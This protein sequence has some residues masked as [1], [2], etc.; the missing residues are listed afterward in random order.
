[1]TI[2]LGLVLVLAGVLVAVLQVRW[3]ARSTPEPVRRWHVS[4][5]LPR[6]QR[7]ASDLAIGGLI[8]AGA[9]VV[10]LGRPAWT[11]YAVAVGGAAV[12]AVAQAL[13]IRALPDRVD[14]PAA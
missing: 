5:P 6:R 8:V 1:V 2:A 3:A 12:T 9:V 10:E 11:F 4:A 14:H 13:A 7:Y